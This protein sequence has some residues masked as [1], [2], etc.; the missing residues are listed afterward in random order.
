ME[1]R[2]CRNVFLAMVLPPT[3]FVTPAKA[4]VHGLYSQFWRNPQAMD[5]RLRGND[6]EVGG[7]L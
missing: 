4:G 3:W 7:K 2:Y 6:K 5:S 1:D